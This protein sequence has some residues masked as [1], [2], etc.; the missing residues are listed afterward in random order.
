[1]SSSACTRATHT[2]VHCPHRAPS[3]GALHCLCTACGA[4]V[5]QGGRYNF[6]ADAV[7]AEFRSLRSSLRPA[8]PPLRY[9]FGRTMPHLCM[10]RRCSGPRTQCTAHTIRSFPRCTADSVRRV[11]HRHCRDSRNLTSL[12]SLPLAF[13]P[14]PTGLED[15]APEALCQEKTFFPAASFAFTDQGN[16][17]GGLKGE[18]QR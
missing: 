8:A 3:L 18:D 17:Y 13:P 6:T 4:G 14:R 12:A 9:K 10:P 1:M 11:W 7:R 5:Y 2:R 16:H 15:H